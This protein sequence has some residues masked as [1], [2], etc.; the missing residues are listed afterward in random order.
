VIIEEQEKV[1]ENDKK[2][3][4]VSASA[5][6][7]KTYVVINYITKL[8]CEKKVPIKDFVILT[9][10]KAAASEMKERLSKTLKALGDDP[11]IVE[12]LDAL[13]ISNISTIHAFCEK[14]LKKYANLI[15]LNSNFEV[16][17][18]NQTKKILQ[19]AFENSVTRFEK[20]Q[21]EEFF[22]LMRFYK[23]DKNQIREILFEL[24]NLVSAVANREEFLQ[25]NIKNPEVYFKKALKFLFDDVRQSLE[26]LMLE[27][28]KLHVDEFEISLKKALAD[29]VS[30]IDIFDLAKSV[31]NFKF[32][33]L[34][35]RKEVGD[36]IVD[37][38]NK[39]KKNI[40][41]LISGIIE[42][43][44]DDEENVVSQSRASLESLLLKLYLI[45]SK[46][47]ERLKKLQN[48]L[49]FSDLEKYM[50]ILSEKENLF[51]DI[52]YVFIDEYQDTNKIQEKIVKNIAENCNFVAVG[53]VKQGIYGFR[54]ASCEIFLKDME[55]FERDEN[56]TLN[57]LKS[58]FRSSQKVLDFVNDVFKVC[59]T[60]ASAGI[61][62]A[63]TSMLDGVGEFKEEKA[64]S[65]NIDVVLEDKNEEEQLPKLYSVMEAE[66]KF[67][68]TNQKQLY[69]VKNRILEVMRSE[70][71]ENGQ[72]RKCRFSDIAI[73]LRN[74]SG[75]LFDE[76]EEFLLENNI[77]VLS[78]SRNKLFD[79]VEMRVLLNWLKLALNF[80]DEIAMLSVLKSPFGCFSLENIVEIMKSEE[81]TLCQVVKEEGVFECINALME[82]FRF[83]CQVLGIRLAFC[84]LFDKTNYR[85]YLNS[86]KNQ[87]SLNN[88]VDTF[89]N[90]ISQSG[91]EF[92]IAG[93]IN[94]FETV[95]ITVVSQLSADED[96]VV[97]TTIHNSKGLEFPIV[98]LCGCDKSLK[99]GAN[100]GLVEVNEEF[101]F[102]VKKYD[103]EKNQ[104]MISVRM[105]AT[106]LSEKRKDFVEELMIFYVALTRAKNRLY[107]FGKFNENILK[108]Y[109]VFDCDSY[110]DLIF[111]ALPK[112]KT[113]FLEGDHF[114]SENIEA[115]LIENIEELSL[116]KNEASE[117]FGYDENVVSELKKYLDF[118]YRFDN[119]HNFKL[120]ESVT[121]LN[122]R[123]LEDISQ[124]YSNENFSFGGSSVEEGNAYHLALKV[125]NFDKI[126]NA[127][128]LESE[129]KANENALGKNMELIDKN[130]LLKN[131]LLLKEF[132]K[133]GQVFKEKQFILKEK[134]CNLI[135]KTA[136][137]DKI[138]V[139]G[140]IDFYVLNENKIILIDYKYSQ[141]INEEKLINKYKNQLKLYKIALE[142]A[143]NLP[144]EKSYLLSLKYGKLIEIN[145]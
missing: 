112:L 12:Q 73:L 8:I 16:A 46:E 4:L 27:V 45:F 113:A 39:I 111:F 128:D 89:L 135:E 69:A 122:K 21:S 88:F 5:G 132:S 50:E 75:G 125:L 10:T 28:Q 53:D 65:V 51:D 60:N 44:L 54:L 14:C 6:S 104:E 22:E 31:Q 91:F 137:S 114:V 29:I 106:R 72:Y 121:N 19:E 115:N 49:S 126:E 30:S 80:D 96:A 87:Q 42:L 107:L 94:F 48:V 78:N 143:F 102:S 34:P 127:L 62:Y 83:D 47:S 145:I 11:F 9:F 100:L 20:E 59:M 142:N 18:E 110:F 66:P 99:A 97:L 82:E 36:D 95:E 84:N 64:H 141:I 43:S 85:A 56:S 98:F 133:Q 7:G 1:Y 76:L 74:R 35:K 79:E 2:N 138:L 61:D 118:E 108:R 58:N 92:D 129:L 134:L 25:S 144:V 140:I 71:Y 67:L 23:N 17:D 70:I 123:Q 109:S 55:D 32:P 77:P 120:K 117:N 38:L 37:A 81:R 13:S 139:Q 136:C 15:D 116:E 3:M 119:N 68:K 41:K 124:H 86:F 63:S 33:F 26:E 93:L 90:S 103:T 57:C 24:E 52:K 40:N 105:K 130:I 101:G 131:I